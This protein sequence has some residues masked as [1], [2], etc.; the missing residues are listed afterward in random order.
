[1][2]YVLFVEN[3]S[4]G[5]GDKETGVNQREYQRDLQLGRIQSKTAKKQLVV[6]CSQQGGVVLIQDSSECRF[7]EL[8]DA[9]GQGMGTAEDHCHREPLVWTDKSVTTRL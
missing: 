6:P 3:C 4:T 7:I 8:K 1:V 9:C 5:G 2:V